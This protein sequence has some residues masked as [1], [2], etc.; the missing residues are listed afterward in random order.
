MHLRKKKWYKLGRNFHSLSITVKKMGANFIFQGE[1]REKLIKKVEVEETLKIK[2]TK[3]EK[4]K[5]Y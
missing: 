1:K 3:T 5:K 4:K 2:K